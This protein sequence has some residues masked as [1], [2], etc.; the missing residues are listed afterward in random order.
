MSDTELDPK[1]I[2]S[3]KRL[4]GDLSD[5]VKQLQDAE[6]SRQKSAAKEEVKEDENALKNYAKAHG[7]SLADAEEAISNV[8]RSRQKSEMKEILKELIAESGDEIFGSDEPE[9]EEKEEEKK[10]EKPDTA[11]VGGAHW[12]DR[13]MF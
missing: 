7:I 9:P 10:E 12:T 13:R 5:S 1:E 4:L 6:T 2:A 3:I 8:K 11:P